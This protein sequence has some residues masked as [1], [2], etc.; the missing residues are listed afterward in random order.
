MFQKISGQGGSEKQKHGLACQI[1]I[2]LLKTS[3]I[4]II[5][6]FAKFYL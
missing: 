4:T 3:L 2:G 6:L 1:I 5:I